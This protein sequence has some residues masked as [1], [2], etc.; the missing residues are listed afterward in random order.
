MK[1]YQNRLHRYAF[2]K[3]LLVK[4]GYDKNKTESTIMFENGYDKIWDC[5]S[6]KFELILIESLISNKKI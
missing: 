2:R 5:G 4:N 6:L 3:N 1:N